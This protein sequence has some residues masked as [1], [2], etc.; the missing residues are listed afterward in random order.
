LKVRLAEV[1]A[2]L[3]EAHKANRRLEDILRTAQREKLGN[4]SKKLSPDQFNLLREDA[5]F[6]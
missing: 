6:A 4:R 2:A 5:E 1:E 3:T